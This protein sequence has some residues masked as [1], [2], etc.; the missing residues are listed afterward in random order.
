MKKGFAA[1]LCLM[2]LSG[3]GSSDSDL[4]DRI[5]DELKQLAVADQFSGANR[6]KRR[7]SYYLPKGMGQRDANELSE[8]LMKDGYR[9]IMNFDPGAIVIK[10]Y[11]AD[12]P[13]ET[14]DG[15]N[16]ESTKTD[17]RE[18][19]EALGHREDVP[20]DAP[21]EEIKESEAE[22]ADEETAEPLSLEVSV[23]QKA[24]GLYFSGLFQNERKEYH[25]YTLRLLPSDNAY[26][27]YL[28]GSYVKLYSVVPRAE[29]PSMLKAM[30][31]LMRSVHYEKEEI[32]KAYSLKSLTQTK[33][34]SL[35]YLEQHLPSSGSLQELLSGDDASGDVNP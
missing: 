5:A 23:E 17:M 14:E 2:L 7:Y 6:T 16:E 1:V 15:E 25:P 4:P 33:K 22:T 34:E 18:N 32:L 35:D 24:D 30:F 20:L 21:D 11:Y 8:V 28:N 13:Q 19:Q 12:E 10:E 27:V 29:I 3:C 26:L 31:T 9:V